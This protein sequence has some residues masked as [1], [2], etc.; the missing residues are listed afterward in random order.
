MQ[1]HSFVC[2]S[3][4]NL[5]YVNVQI[6]SFSVCIFVSG[7]ANSAHSEYSDSFRKSAVLAVHMTALGGLQ[8]KHKWFTAGVWGKHE[9]GVEKAGR[10]GAGRGLVAVVRRGL[11]PWRL[12]EEEVNRCPQAG[13]QAHSG[14]GA[15]RQVDIQ[16]H[17][18]TAEWP[19]SQA[20]LCMENASTGVS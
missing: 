9:R 20:E 14:R 8:D 18:G 7:A 17:S 15:E 11:Q 6:L 5:F 2:K 3:I 13:R 4:P 12:M 19:R 16:E 1:C 10:R